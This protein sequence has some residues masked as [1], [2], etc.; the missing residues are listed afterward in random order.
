MKNSKIYLLII[1]IAFLS[2]SCKEDDEIDDIDKGITS[3]FMFQEN[4]TY[5]YDVEIIDEDDT[6]N[7]KFSL[8][9][10]NKV[11]IKGKNALHY[12]FYI[13]DSSFEPRELYIYMDKNQ[14]YGLNSFL[15][16]HPGMDLVLVSESETLEKM[17]WQLCFDFSN[18]VFESNYHY[19]YNENYELDYEKTTVSSNMKCNEIKDTTY[20]FNGKIEEAIKFKIK[21]NILVVSEYND[22]DYEDDSEEIVFSRNVI[23]V[24]GIGIVEDNYS[25]IIKNTYLDGEIDESNLETIIKLKEIK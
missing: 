4:K 23:F 20:L 22:E 13:D 11:N 3:D 14:I 24:K 8:I 25:I 15:S 18:P 9:T 2:F 16:I 5:D 7:E 17:N 6:Q 12:K 19:I 1:A 10:F 21:Q